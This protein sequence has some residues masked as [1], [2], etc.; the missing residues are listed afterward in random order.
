V[1]LPYEDALVALKTGELDGVAWSGITE[2]YTVGWAD[3][4]KYFLTNNIAGAW[5]GHFFANTQSWNK[6]PPH[7]QALFKLAMDS[8]HYYRQ[9][10]YW[11]GEADYR[12][13]GSKL[14]LTTIPEAEWATVEA[15]AMKFWDDIAKKG[16]TAKKVVDIFRKYNAMMSKAGKPYRYA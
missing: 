16:P 13:N 4:T 2:D 7:L 5:I 15:E 14:K 3:N 1:D 9:H 11:G 6:V 8:S 10:W 12:V